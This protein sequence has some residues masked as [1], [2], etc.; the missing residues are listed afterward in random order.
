[1]KELCQRC[2][3][4]G[5]DRRTL[6]MACFYAMEELG[7]PFEKETII[8]GGINDG[9]PNQ[10]YNFY[11]LRVCKECRAQWMMAIKS[12][13]DTVPFKH[14]VGS[15][16]FIR[17]LGATVEVSEETFRFLNPGIEPT[18]FKTS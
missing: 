2:K 18:K 11:N 10:K 8:E 3:E 13:F 4:D 7:L 12:W 1:M 15:G 17:H 14:E 9:H 6:W 16:I 5:E